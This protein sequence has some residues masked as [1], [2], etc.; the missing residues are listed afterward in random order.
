MNPNSSDTLVGEIGLEL[1][2]FCDTGMKY[3]STVGNGIGISLTQKYGGRVGY[4]EGTLTGFLVIGK[5]GDFV[6]F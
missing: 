4:S 1:E 5:V 2:G 6:T 3:G